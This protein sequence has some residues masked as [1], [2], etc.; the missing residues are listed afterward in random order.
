MN[1][2]SPAPDG[3]PRNSM[4]TGFAIAVASSACRSC[5]V[6]YESETPT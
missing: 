3:R 4:M 5:W 1:A 2:P 6:P